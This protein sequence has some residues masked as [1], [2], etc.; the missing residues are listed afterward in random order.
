MQR[1]FICH[2]PITGISP[3]VFS[4]P[5]SGRQYSGSFLNQS[6]LSFDKIRLS[7]DFYVDKLLEPVAEYGAVFLEACFPRSFV[8]VN[9][10]SMEL[11]QKLISGLQEISTNPRTLAGLGV[12]PR[13]VGS[14]LELYRT[15]I[16]I[17]EV[18]RR[19]NKYY[20]PYHQKLKSIIRQS[21]K[22]FGFTII[23]DFHSMPHS[24]VSHSQTKGSFIPQV[25]LG[26]C[27]GTSC[28]V[29]LSKKVF[30]IFDN[31]GLRVEMNKP[32]SGGFIT[33]NYGMPKKNIHTIQVE[34]DRSLYINE[35]DYS[36]HSGYLDLKEQLRTVIYKL[37][38][39]KTQDH[40]LFHAAE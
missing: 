30:E 23:F 9:R 14:G 36:L 18:E 17:D 8:D 19:L 20:F 32:F 22:T 29:A 15:K 33:K 1:S 39:L 31:A 27:F 38:K 4:S 25:V 26:D 5:H 6:T 40:N 13:V 10:S 28:D 7:E 11:D 24:C 37:S 12:I 2:N 21:I 16:S 3:I 35:K 34:I